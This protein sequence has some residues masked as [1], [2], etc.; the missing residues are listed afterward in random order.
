MT[1]VVQERSD[2]PN[3]LIPDRSVGIHAFAT[4]VGFENLVGLQAN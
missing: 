3:R 2:Y 4:P 1:L